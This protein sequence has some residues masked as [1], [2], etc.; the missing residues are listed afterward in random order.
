[1]FHRITSYNVCY[2][3]LLRASFSWAIKFDPSQLSAYA[4]ASLTKISIYN[5]TDAVDELRIYKGT[6][7]ATLLHTQALSGLGMETFV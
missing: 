1:M 2:T 6:N 4:G 7:A 3:K 5:R